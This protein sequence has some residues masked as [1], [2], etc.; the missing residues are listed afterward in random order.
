MGP[1]S[2][3]SS[4]ILVTGASSGIGRAC[5]ILCS[6]LG[7]RIILL[8]RD[9]ARLSETV[10][11]MRGDSHLKYSVDLTRQDELDATV[12]LI[13]REGIV[14]DGVLHCAGISTIL[15]FKSVSP[16]K[17]NEFLQT[18]VVGPY[19][20]T[21]LILKGG[22][23]SES[24]ASIVFLSSVMGTLG[25]S[26]RSLY[27]LT[28]ASLIGACK[29]LAVELAAKKIR[30]NCISPGVVA[31]PM[32]SRSLYNQDDESREKVRSL[33]PLGF[34][35]PKDVANACVFLLSSASK[36]ITGTDLVVDG[37]YSAK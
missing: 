11:Q 7:A 30:V 9:E 26:G 24:G 35:E 14:I 27:G 21:R 13:K 22:L 19:Q 17:M 16:N 18:N 12:G 2:L 20:L 10:R 33:H 37:G 23:L 15:P 32:S 8:G 25:E 1:F 34:G 4:T 36:W 28:K 5:A 6:E 31:T 29:S 3:D